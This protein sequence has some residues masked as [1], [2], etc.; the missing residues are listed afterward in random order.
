[1][2]KFWYR[3]AYSTSPPAQKEFISY[4]SDKFE[5][6]R[7]KVKGLKLKIGDN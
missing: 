4:L 3:E 1:M 5:V 7:G 6:G 2:F